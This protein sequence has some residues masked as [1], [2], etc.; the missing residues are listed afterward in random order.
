MTV[1]VSHRGGRRSEA[2]SEASYESAPNRPTL[3]APGPSPFI[4]DEVGSEASWGRRGPGKAAPHAG[5][6]FVPEQGPFVAEQEHYDGGSPDK[7][8]LFAAQRNAPWRSNLLRRIDPRP[9]N[10]G[11]GSLHPPPAPSAAAH[12]RWQSEQ[13]ISPDKIVSPAAM[14][15]AILKVR[16]RV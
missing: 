4:P 1:K 15:Q 2:Q 6:S 11:H 10:L 14:D 12:E 16:V 8:S 9:P 3:G 13:E 5:A 7:S